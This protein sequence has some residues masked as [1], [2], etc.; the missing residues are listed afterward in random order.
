M[1]KLANAPLTSCR[2]AKRVRRHACQ[3]V[4]QEHHPLGSP[5][6]RPSVD[7]AAATALSIVPG[8]TAAAQI[9]RP[10]QT[11]WLRVMLRRPTR[12]EAGRHRRCI[13]EGP[14]RSGSS[15]LRLATTAKFD[16][17]I[18]PTRTLPC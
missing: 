16:E 4:G 9:A 10:I 15:G 6:A 1:A 3:S 17:A 7:R 5:G 13:P 2:A 14:M 8:T 18:S 11:V 12:P